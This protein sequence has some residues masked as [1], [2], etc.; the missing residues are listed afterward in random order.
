MKVRLAAGFCAVALLLMGVS[1]LAQVAGQEEE[2]FTVKKE[3]YAYTSA[4]N[5]DPFLSLIKP[6]TAKERREGATPL[7][8]YDLSQMQLV[9]VVS[10][11]QKGYALLR[12]PD[13]K[14]YTALLGTPMGLH[15]GKITSISS[16]SIV[17]EEQLYDYKGRLRTEEKIIRRRKEEEE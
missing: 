15:A 13:G 4:G 9:A 6:K 16:D 5:R 2:R 3:P 10:D 8:S 17:V 1:A 14:H 12:L 11:V 7:E